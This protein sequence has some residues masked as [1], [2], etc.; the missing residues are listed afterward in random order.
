MVRRAAGLRPLRNP[1]M[2]VD[3][4]RLVAAAARTENSSLS[5]RA[6]HRLETWAAALF[7]L[8]LVLIGAAIPYI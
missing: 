5:A 7:L 4:F 8:V 1:S 2:V 3:V 6:R